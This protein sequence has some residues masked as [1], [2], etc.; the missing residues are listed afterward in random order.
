MLR[1]LVYIYIL[2]FSLSTASS[3]SAK[4][5]GIYGEDNR[6][7]VQELPQQITT[8]QLAA[9]VF[10][11]SNSDYLSYQPHSQQYTA[12]TLDD[13]VSKMPHVRFSDQKLLGFCTAFLVS[14]TT[15][16]TAT[17]CVQDFIIED[18]GT[19]YRE[20]YALKDFNG[21]Q[22]NSSLTLPSSQVLKIKS[23]IKQVEDISILS[24]E[25]PV[26][27]RVPLTLRTSAEAPSLNTPLSMI[28]FPWGRTKVYTDHATLQIFE[29]ETTFYTNLDGFEGNSGSPVFDSRTYEVVGVFSRG[30]ADLKKSFDNNNAG[31]PSY[32]EAT[33]AQ[34]VLGELVTS[35]HILNQKP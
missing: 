17:H 12:I 19:P 34:D 20:I 29:D 18:L 10:L 6:T 11:L 27:D 24:L 28:G 25:E 4:V 14:P 1:T 21:V 23:L 2:I 13:S 15:I 3:S 31:T 7:S 30:R 8:T 32:S 33:Y 9:S 26:L 35:T 5:L 16:A 22:R